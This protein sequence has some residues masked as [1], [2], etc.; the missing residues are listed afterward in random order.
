MP[1]RSIAQVWTQRGLLAR[2]EVVTI[3]QTATSA[4]RASSTHRMPA[5]PRTRSGISNACDLSLRRIVTSP[6]AVKEKKASRSAA[7]V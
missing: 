4:T 2:I 1:A 5:P 6:F 3:D 7:R